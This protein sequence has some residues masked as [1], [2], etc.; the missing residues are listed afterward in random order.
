MNPVHTLSLYLLIDLKDFLPFELQFQTGRFTSGFQN[1]T[2]FAYLISRYMEY[3]SHLYPLH[4]LLND[5]WI[6]AVHTVM[7]AAVHVIV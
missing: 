4:K 6:I 7:H 1:V 2:F 5:I 3:F